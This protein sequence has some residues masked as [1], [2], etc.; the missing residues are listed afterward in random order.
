MSVTKLGRPGWLDGP[1]LDHHTLEQVRLRTAEQVRAGASPEVK[2]QALGFN[3]AVID[4]CRQGSGTAGWTYSKPSWFLCDPASRRAGSLRASIRRWRGRIRG[5][6]GFP[7][8]SGP[9][10]WLES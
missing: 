3:R 9:R 4:G 10:R 5:S 1:Q 2:A 7:L 6:C 8:G